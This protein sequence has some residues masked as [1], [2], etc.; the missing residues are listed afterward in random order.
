MM[1]LSCLYPAS[2]PPAPW[3]HILVCLPPFHVNVK[4]YLT[5]LISASPVCIGGFAYCAMDNLPVA[6]SPKKSDCPFP[7]SHQSSIALRKVWG[8]WNPSQLHSGIANCLDPLQEA[9]APANSCVRAISCPGNTFSSHFSLP[10]GS[11]IPSDPSS[12]KFPESCGE[13]KVDVD[14]LATAE[15]SPSPILS[16]SNPYVSLY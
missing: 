8:T 13:E 10:S 4:L 16:T 3:L 12:A 2:L 14:A 11:Y 1:H 9:T 6:T 5:S 7:S 15:H